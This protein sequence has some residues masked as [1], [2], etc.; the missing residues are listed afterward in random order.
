M[1]DTC[2]ATERWTYRKVSFKM[3]AGPSQRQKIN[4]FLA[5]LRQVAYGSLLPGKRYVQFPDM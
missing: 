2:E 5:R 1:A 4:R 3:V